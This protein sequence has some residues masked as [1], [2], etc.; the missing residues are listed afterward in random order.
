MKLF[1]ELCETGKPAQ[2]ENAMACKVAMDE[3]MT[4]LRNPDDCSDRVVFILPQLPPAHCGLGDYS[5]ILLGH[6]R[7]DPPPRILVMK[8]AADTRAVH[9]E[10]DVEELPRTSGGLLA[11]LRELRAKRVFV[12]YVAQG[13]Q[14]RGCPLWFLSALRRWREQ[15][16]DARLVMMLQELWFEPSWWKPDW[17]LQK[18]HRRALQRLARVV[19]NVFVSTHSFADRMRGVA[20]PDRLQ[21]LMN[22]AT[23][24]LVGSV[25]EARRERG[26]MVLFGRQGS[27]LLALTEMVPWLGRLHSAGVLTKLLLVGSRENTAMNEREDYLVRSQLS[28]DASEVLGS[29]TAEELSRTFLKAE[30]GIF[31]KISHGYTK[32]TIFM[33]YASHGLSILSPEAINNTCEPLCWVT[34]PLQLLEGKVTPEQIQKRGRKL[35]QWYEN[36]ASWNRVADTY[37]EALSLT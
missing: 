2:T 12:Q 8:G 17:L 9:P 23:I 25:A 6:M 18:F 14:P 35:A 32:S 26:H 28:A 5:M 30:M 20:A 21:V 1:H 15:T 10:F 4:M 29:Q 33:G 24:P 36:S 34:H 27:R 13:F 7:M 31:A 11:H 16:P 3:T 22:P 19:D 37:R